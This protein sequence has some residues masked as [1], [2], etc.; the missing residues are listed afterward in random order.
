MFNHQTDRALRDEVYLGTAGCDANT[1]A[2]RGFA[3]SCGGRY[4]GP[5]VRVPA[6]NLEADRWRPFVWAAIMFG[7]VGTLT[8]CAL[9]ARDIVGAVITV[10]DALGLTAR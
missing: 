2:G 7:C 9:L 6:V 1:L 3:R 5:E 4:Y 8:I 10:G